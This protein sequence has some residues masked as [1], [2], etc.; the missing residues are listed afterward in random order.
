[1]ATHIGWCLLPQAGLGLGF[2][3]IAAE[4]F[5]K[6]GSEVLSVVIGTTVAFEI[7]GPIATSLSL[8]HAGEISQSR[9]A[10]PQEGH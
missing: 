10:E 1:M 2:G 3:L 4:R 9:S 5:P 6:V 7:V 8:K